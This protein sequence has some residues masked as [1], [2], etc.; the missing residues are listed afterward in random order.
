[1]LGKLARVWAHETESMF[2]PYVDKCKIYYAELLN[3][4]ET[5][6]FETV[7]INNLKPLLNN[8]MKCDNARIIHF[9]EDILEW[10]EYT[11]RRTRKMSEQEKIDNL[12]D[13][14]FSVP[15][16]ERI[17]KMEEKEKERERKRKDDR[18]PKKHTRKKGEGGYCRVTSNGIEYWRYSR[19][20]KGERKA[21]YGKTKA[22]AYRNYKDYMDNLDNTRRK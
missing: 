7:L 14:I 3:S 1:M 13:R 9:D 15:L 6:I 19:M 5:T 8:Q 20:V 17:K 4:A 2:I 10:K 11:G 18:I 16:E 21:T 12:I 22:E